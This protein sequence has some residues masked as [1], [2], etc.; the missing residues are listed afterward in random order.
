MILR[1]EQH[2]TAQLLEHDESGMGY[3]VATIN[4]KQYLVLNATVALPIHQHN[5]LQYGFADNDIQCLLDKRNALDEA[6]RL[7]DAQELNNALQQ[8]GLEALN[9]TVVKVEP[10]GSYSATSGTRELFVRYSAFRRDFRIDP[11]NGSVLPN[12][13]VTTATDAPHV[14]SG[15]AAVGRYALP[16]PAPA[17]YEFTIDPP[18]GSPIHCG[19]VAPKF[20]Q[21]GGGVE[22]LFTAGFVLQGAV[23]GPVPILER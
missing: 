12:T 9:G 10:H 13:Y 18:L 2:L 15:L 8:L 23:Q 11:N 7:E 22:V 17:L 1:L 14:P 19:T 4:G 21:A 3:Q 16:N 6:L 20:G 5:G